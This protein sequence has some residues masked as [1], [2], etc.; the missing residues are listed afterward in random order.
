MANPIPNLGNL[1]QVDLRK[2]WSH[3]AHDF[4]HWLASEENLTTLSDAIGLEITLIEIEATVG[5]FNVDILAEEENTGRKIVIENQLEVTNHDHL[6]KIITY[7]SGHDAEIVIWIVKSVREEHRQA[8]DWLNE[9]TDDQ[10]Y[11]FLIKMEAWRIGNSNIAPKFNV[12]SQ[13]NDWAKAIKASE[14]KR[15]LTETKLLQLE[16]WTKL[17]EYAAENSRVRFGHKAAAQHWYNIS[18][19]NSEYHIALTLN[20]FKGIIACSLYIHDSK[21][22]FKEFENRKEEIENKL[23]Y[24]VNWHELEGKKAASLDISKKANYRDQE[25]WEKQFEWL[26]SKV[27]DFYRVFGRGNNENKS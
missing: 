16:Y 17:K 2:V 7:A 4:T 27:E 26:V 8:L 6:G 23:G 15:G 12:V 14:G 25:S 24:K 9:H 3:E 10:T 22:I 1:E 18:I 19:G 13:P 20:M 11:F 5:K 21:E